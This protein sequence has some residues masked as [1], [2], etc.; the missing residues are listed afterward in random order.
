MQGEDGADHEP[1]TQHSHPGK[2][3]PEFFRSRQKILGLRQSHYHRA[4]AGNGRDANDDQDHGIVF[5]LYGGA[6]FHQFRCGSGHHPPKRYQVSP[7]ACIPGYQQLRQVRAL[8]QD[9][10]DHD[11]YQQRNHQTRVCMKNQATYIHACPQL[12]PISRCGEPP[13]VRLRHFYR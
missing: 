3:V 11:A 9:R 13:L 12:N 2:Q 8:R 1:R 6:A 7:D 10:P 5:I 4:N